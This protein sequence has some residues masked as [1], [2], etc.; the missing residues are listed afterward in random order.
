MPWMHANKLLMQVSISYLEIY[1]EVGYD[2]L[3][4][5]RDIRGLEDLQRVQAMEAENGEIH[6]RNLFLHP[7]SNVEEALNL[8]QIPNYFLCCIVTFVAACWL[9]LL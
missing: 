8:V 5:G 6:L 9:T 2:L 4:P 3:D 7:A 1:N